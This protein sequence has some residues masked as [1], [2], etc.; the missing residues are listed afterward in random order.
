MRS[1]R[2]LSA[3]SSSTCEELT[4]ITQKSQNDWELQSTIS[5]SHVIRLVG[6]KIQGFD[7]AKWLKDVVNKLS[8]EVYRLLLWALTW[9]ATLM[10]T[11]LLSARTYVLFIFQD[12]ELMFFQSQLVNLRVYSVLLLF[13]LNTLEIDLSSRICS[14]Q[15]K[16]Y[17]WYSSANSHSDWRRSNQYYILHY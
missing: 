12:L 9:I 17:N 5:E 13:S 16:W 6:Q 8:V 3:F 4:S 11:S 2:N 15:M 7:S 1:T 10:S 14:F